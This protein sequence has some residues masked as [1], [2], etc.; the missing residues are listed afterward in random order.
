MRVVLRGT[1]FEAQL[2][3][4]QSPDER[5][6]AMLAATVLAWRRA[7]TGRNRGRGRLRAWIQDDEWMRAQFN[8]F[9]REVGG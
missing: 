7:G 5:E 3:F 6:R 8:F 4:D 1:V 9:E 2:T